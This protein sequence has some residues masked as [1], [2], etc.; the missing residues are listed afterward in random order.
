MHVSGSFWGFL[1]VFF[2]VQIFFYKPFL[3]VAL[4][5]EIYM[6]CVL[7]HSLLSFTVMLKNAISRCILA[8]TFLN[9]MKAFAKISFF[10]CRCVFFKMTGHL[11][12]ADARGAS[13]RVP[14]S[15][16]SCRF[17]GKLAKV[18]YPGSRAIQLF[19]I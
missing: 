8:Q 17:R 16:V 19:Y 4:Y 1:L 5:M 9:I 10:L 14:F 3:S 6:Q 13:L 7:L 11:D 18:L 12:V 15:F 2:S